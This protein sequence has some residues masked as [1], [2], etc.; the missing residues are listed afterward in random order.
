MTGRNNHSDH[1]LIDMRWLSSIL[2]IRNFKGTDCDT[3]QYYVVAKF[4]ERLTESKQ[5]KQN[6]DGE[7]FN[8][9]KLNE[10]E[11]RKQNQIE[12]TNRFA[13]LEN[14]NNDEDINRVWE[15]VKEFIKI[16]AKE[17]LGLHDLKRHKPWFHEESLNFLDQRKQTNMHSVQDPIQNNAENLKNIRREAS[18]HFRNKSK[19]HLKAKIEEHDCTSL[20][21]GR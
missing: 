18:R 1:I 11:F 2:N 3:D 21:K 16:S 20:R 4:R 19:A 12:I 6:L 5:E 7:R 9:R 14:L 17:S 13:A 10:M 8:L 15:N